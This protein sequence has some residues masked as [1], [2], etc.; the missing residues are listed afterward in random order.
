LFVLHPN[1]FLFNYD[2]MASV[3]S[4]KAIRIFLI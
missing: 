1:A 4:W 3:T 2:I